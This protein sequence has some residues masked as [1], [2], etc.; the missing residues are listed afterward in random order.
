[1]VWSS[2]VFSVSLGCSCI[3]SSFRLPLTPVFLHSRP[4]CTI[5]PRRPKL[6]LRGYR[7]NVQ[8][9]GPTHHR[10]PCNQGPRFRANRTVNVAVASGLLMVVAKFI[11]WPKTTTK[12]FTIYCVSK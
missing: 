3:E 2:A 5:S 1:M 6:C 4:R 8:L 12:C 10:V 9:V 7:D 11:L